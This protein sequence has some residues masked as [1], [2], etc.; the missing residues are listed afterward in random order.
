MSDKIKE[1]SQ[2][3]FIGEGKDQKLAAK[4][5]IKYRS[6]LF[7]E[8]V[9]KKIIEELV[10]DAAIGIAQILAENLTNQATQ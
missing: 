5:I 1:E 2:K 6:V 7:D 9:D 10:N 8:I 4:I 3:V